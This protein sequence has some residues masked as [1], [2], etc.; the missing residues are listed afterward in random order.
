MKPSTRTRPRERKPPR[1]L[2]TFEATTPNG[3]VV[4]DGAP[5]GR[6]LIVSGVFGAELGGSGLYCSVE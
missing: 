2:A 4:D 6:R 5:C 3:S 1:T